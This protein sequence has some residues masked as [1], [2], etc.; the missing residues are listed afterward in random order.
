MPQLQN[1]PICSQIAATISGNQ[2]RGIVVMLRP[3]ATNTWV[4]R[5][6]CNN[7]E[8]VQRSILRRQQFSKT[9]T[10]SR[11]NTPLPKTFTPKAATW[12]GFRTNVQDGRRLRRTT[13][14]EAVKANLDR[15]LALHHRVG[16]VLL[17]I[18]SSNWNISFTTT[19]IVNRGVE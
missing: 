7:L 16:E 1:Y 19:Q 18:S 8:Q 13:T 5:R 9:I 10:S 14:A 15:F 6:K 4:A 12:K 3:G 2:P 11:H 17:L